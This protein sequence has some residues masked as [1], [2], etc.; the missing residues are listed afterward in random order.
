MQAIFLPLPFALEFSRAEHGEIHIA[1]TEVTGYYKGFNA[2]G[3]DM[4]KL[5]AGDLEAHNHYMNNPQETVVTP[6]MVLAQ[7]EKYNTVDE[8]GHL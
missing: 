7:I 8:D 2:C 1:L 3:A 4:G 6:E 5:K